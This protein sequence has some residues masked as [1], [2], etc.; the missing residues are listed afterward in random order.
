[1]G[2]VPAKSADYNLTTPDNGSWRK[3]IDVNRRRMHDA[4][5]TEYSFFKFGY[6]HKFGF[7][8]S[9]GGAGC[10]GSVLGVERVVDVDQSVGSFCQIAP[11]SLPPVCTHK[12]VIAP[13]QGERGHLRNRKC[14]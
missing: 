11:K 6:E 7:G 8:P 9:P 10:N 5:K 14:P 4:I 12:D 1:M 13:V 3:Q 2:D